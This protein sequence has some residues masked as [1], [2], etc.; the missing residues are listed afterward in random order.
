MEES[1]VDFLAKIGWPFDKLEKQGFASPVTRVECKFVRPSTFSDVITIQTSVKSFDGI[2]LTFE[3]KMEKTDG[4]VVC[5]GT[6]VHCFI[7]LKGKPIRA[8]RA[9]PEFFEEL[10]KHRRTENDAR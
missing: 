4:T 3:Y 10:L 1:R 2:R 5:T 9:C 6:S 7:D 8:D